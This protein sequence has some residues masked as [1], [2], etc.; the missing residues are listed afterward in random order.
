MLESF[1]VMRESAYSTLGTDIL[2]INVLGTSLVVLDS[3][4]AATDLLERRSSRYSGRCAHFVEM[5]PS[6]LNLPI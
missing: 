5:V 2:Y 3:S 1:S 6:V 4:E